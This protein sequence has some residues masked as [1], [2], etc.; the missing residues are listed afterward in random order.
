MIIRLQVCDKKLEQC[1]FFVDTKNIFMVKKIMV[2]FEV[3]NHD[4]FRRL[5]KRYQFEVFCTV[6]LRG[7]NL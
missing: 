1:I 3:M 2:H 4:F 5:K 7:Y 6:A